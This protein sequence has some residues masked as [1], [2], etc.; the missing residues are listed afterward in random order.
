[1]KRYG[2]FL[3]TVRET[4][5]WNTDKDQVH[6]VGV[7]CAHTGVGFRIQFS[8]RRAGK[9][10]VWDYSSRLIS[11][12]IV[13]LSPADDAFQSKCIIAVVAARQLDRVKQQPPEIDIFWARPNETE[14][15]PQVEWIMVE[16]RNSYYEASRYTLRALQKLSGER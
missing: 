10:I 7:T 14:F 15:D 13:A 9:N 11:G 2:C 1:M 3:T 5:S 8:T 6:I 16:A 12:S 4:R